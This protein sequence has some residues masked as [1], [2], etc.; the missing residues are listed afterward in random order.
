MSGSRNPTYPA[1]SPQ[2]LE[3]HAYKA[4]E[5]AVGQARGAYQVARSNAQVEVTG[6]GNAREWILNMY[7]DRAEHVHDRAAAWNEASQTLARALYI[8]YTESLTTCTEHMT[9]AR[10][11]PTIT[12]IPPWAS[13]PITRPKATRLTSIKLV[14]DSAI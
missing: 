6:T 5:A 7:P 8:F 1:G 3:Y 9:S 4:A 13:M 11:S 10:T 12:Q 2:D 14:S